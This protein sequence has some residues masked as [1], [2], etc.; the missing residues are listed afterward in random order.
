MRGLFIVLGAGLLCAGGA[1]GKDGGG[2]GRGPADEDG[3]ALFNENELND[4]HLTMAPEDWQSILADSRGDEWRRATLR[5]KNETVPD[6]AVHPAGESSRFP[7]NP[8]Q[9]LRLKFTEFVPGRR[10]HGLKSLKLD[11]MWYDPS[12]LRQRLSYWMFRMR[13]PAPR[14]VHSRLFVNGQYRGLYEIEERIDSRLV[15]SRFGGEVGNLYRIRGPGV[16]VDPYRYVGP[17]PAD[18]VPFI[19]DPQENALTGDHTRVVAFCDVLTN[20][21]SSAAGVC[22]L[23]SVLEYFACEAVATDTDGFSSPFATDDHYQYYRLET[24]RFTMIPWDPDNTW[25]SENDPPTRDIFENFDKS[26]LS[27]LLKSDASLR[28]RYKEKIAQVMAQA[29]LQA[30]GAR[31]DF[32]YE[33]IRDAAHADPYKQWENSHF[34]FSRDYVKDFAARRYESLRL[35]RSSP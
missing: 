5:W 2:G 26:R 4:V 13:M 11:G 1:C 7:N 17:D 12:M 28:A 33:Q 18:Y 20:N 35:Q 3:S 25:G 19:W 15:I 22:D 27:I 21:A 32:I 31:V 23:D 14:S 16:D 24:G 30:I 29:D 10:F 8:K 9:S 34:D 6:V